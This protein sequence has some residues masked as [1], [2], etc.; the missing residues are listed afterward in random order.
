MMLGKAPNVEFMLELRVIIFEKGSE[1]RDVGEKNTQTLAGRTSS[2]LFTA[3]CCRLGIV[4]A[5]THPCLA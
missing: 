1:R 5:E 3:E 2:H 4:K